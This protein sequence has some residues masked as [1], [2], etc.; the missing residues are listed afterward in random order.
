MLVRYSKIQTFLANNLLE[1]HLI[2]KR[3]LNLRCNDGSAVI[4]AC[5]ATRTCGQGLRCDS[6]T[7][8]PGY[9]CASTTT[10]TT[11]TCSNGRQAIGSC[12]NGYY[13]GNN[14]GLVCLNNLCC[15]TTGSGIIP[16]DQ[17]HFINLILK[18]SLQ[19]ALMALLVLV[20]VPAPVPLALHALATFVVRIL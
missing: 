18:L 14:Y 11:Q 2:S 13:C 7:F 15:P 19:Y 6:S 10:V 12:I 8:S 20:H 17:F 5:Y 9:C 16:N 3:Q 4:S 1:R